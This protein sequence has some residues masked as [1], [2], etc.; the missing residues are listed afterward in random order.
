M[1]GRP[2]EWSAVLSN[3]ALCAVCLSSAVQTRHV[4]R[5]AAAGFLLQ[6]LPP[7]LGAA[8]LLCPALGLSVETGS[9]NGSWVST[10]VGL[11]LLVFG[12][13]WLNGDHATANTFLGGALLLAAGLDYLGKEGK[14]LAAQAVTIM[15]SL[16]ILII[17]VFTTNGYGAAGSL[18]LGTAGLLA[19]TRLERLLMLRRGDALRCLLAAG[20]W[21]FQQA[22]RTQDLD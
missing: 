13:H 4:N 20:N 12:F 19:G 16:T 18:L 1:A 15:S 8:G 14:A 3:L 6:A 17:S 22:L 2:D 21:A 11:P 9:P 5:G 10:V 7:F